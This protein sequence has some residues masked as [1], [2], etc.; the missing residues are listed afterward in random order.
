MLAVVGLVCEA[1]GKWTRSLIS[2]R[3]ASAPLGCF[4]PSEYRYVAEGTV[5]QHSGVGFGGRGILR[6]GTGWVLASCLL[7]QHVGDVLCEKSGEPENRP[8][9]SVFPPHV[10]K[11][12]P[13]SRMEKLG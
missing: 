4:V 3:L 1:K 2:I 7:L 9:Y 12:D 5:S 11:G 13:H 6:E 8:L 10:Q